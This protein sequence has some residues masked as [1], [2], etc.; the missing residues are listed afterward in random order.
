MIH[1]HTFAQGENQTQDDFNHL[2]DDYQYC[3]VSQYE[4]SPLNLNETYLTEFSP[5]EYQ[6]GCWSDTFV[7]VSLES[8]LTRTTNDMFGSVFAIF[9]GQAYTFHLSVQIGLGEIK[10]YVRLRDLHFP[11]RCV[12]RLLFCNALQLGGCNLLTQG[13]ENP[14]SLGHSNITTFN[15]PKNNGEKLNMYK[16]AD[17]LVSPW[18]M[19]ELRPNKFDNTTHDGDIRLTATLPQTSSGAFF[20]LGHAYVTL[21][22]ENET[23]GI[24]IAKNM[25]DSAAVVSSPPLIQT[26][27]KAMTAYTYIV[28]TFFGLFA[29]SC[30]VFIIYHRKHP[31]M[32]L[33]QGSFLAAL[34]AACFFQIFFCFTYLPTRDIFCTISGPLEI[35]PLHLG[36]AILIARVWR[37][38]SALSMANVIGRKVEDD[39]KGSFRL[40]LSDKYIRL[41]SWLAHFPMQFSRKHRRPVVRHTLRKKVTAAETACL[42]A[43]I[44]LPQVILQ[45]FGA[46]YYH[47]GLEEQI[48]PAGDVGRIVCQARGRWVNE[49]G[50]AIAA[51]VYIGA[52]VVAWIARLLPSVFNEKNQVFH[53][54]FVNCLLAFITIPLVE[55]TNDPNDSP[56]VTVRFSKIVAGFHPLAL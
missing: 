43:M 34:A 9:T 51:L 55:L 35:I 29:L 16:D 18:I 26:V 12:V 39:H 36:G 13:L 54:A 7:N 56:D 2:W 1:Q 22:T 37:A 14:E 45:G 50:I 42:A 17:Y 49:V 48:D 33:S 10:E 6:P 15:P 8:G 53:A 32:T 4:R 46:I 25:I 27:S 47:R 19:V 40:N 38:Y 5:L 41:L 28:S 24:D 30:F 11:I 3:I 31:V 23:I 21:Q 44:T 20:I 52:V